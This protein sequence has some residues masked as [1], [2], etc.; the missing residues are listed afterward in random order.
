MHKRYGLTRLPRRG[1]A[2]I[3]LPNGYG[4][5]SY[6]LKDGLRPLAHEVIRNGATF[7]GLIPKVPS[8]ARRS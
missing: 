1:C 5:R 4:S 6:A 3:V 2:L 7:V 8:D